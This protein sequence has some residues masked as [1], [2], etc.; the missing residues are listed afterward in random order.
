MKVWTEIESRKPWE[1]WTQKSTSNYASFLVRSSRFMRVQMH[2]EQHCHL[3]LGHSDC[4]TSI[5]MSK[6]SKQAIINV[7]KNWI[8]WTASRSGCETLSH[9]RGLKDFEFQ[10]GNSLF[11]LQKWSC[12]VWSCRIPVSKSTTPCLFSNKLIEKKSDCWATF[13]FSCKWIMGTHPTWILR[14][15]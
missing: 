2:S 12:E 14:I 6:N 10:T 11:T 4:F 15:V 9:H 3:L 7:Q 1:T 5:V 8:F 13:I